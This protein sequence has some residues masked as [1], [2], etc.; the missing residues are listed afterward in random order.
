MAWLKF[1][2]IQSKQNDQWR[3]LLEKMT[4]LQNSPQFQH[5]KDN[6]HAGT[7]R[8]TLLAAHP[9]WLWP[10]FFYTVCCYGFT[11]SWDASFFVESPFLISSMIEVDRC[12]SHRE[13]C[14]QWPESPLGSSVLWPTDLPSCLSFLSIQW[15][16]LLTEEYHEHKW[17]ETQP[18]PITPKVI[19]GM[20]VVGWYGILPLFS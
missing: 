18:G 9:E 6:S 10:S 4:N 19:R 17:K 13:C 7:N 12:K 16:Y 11:I 1:Q 14:A 20:N 5:T 8:C 3:F 15:H 2:V